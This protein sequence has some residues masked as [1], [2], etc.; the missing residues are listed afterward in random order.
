MK[1]NLILISEALLLVSSFHSLCNADLQITGRSSL[2]STNIDFGY[3]GNVTSST[4]SKVSTSIDDT[5]FTIQGNATDGGALGDIS[6]DA[7][8][9][10][11]LEQQLVPGSSAGF[12]GFGSTGPFTFVAGDGVSYLSATNRLEVIFENSELTAFDLAY[13][14][15]DTSSLD[16]EQM[17]SPGNWANVH[18]IPGGSKAISRQQYSSLRVCSAWPRRRI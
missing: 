4:E 17:T 16:L 10:F 5:L 8:Y 13:T 18:T 14:A 6:W 7:I 12:G 1:R 3:V 15:T 11:G 9:E 2:L